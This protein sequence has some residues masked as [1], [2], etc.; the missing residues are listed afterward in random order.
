M[1][2]WPIVASMYSFAATP[3]TI[4]MYPKNVVIITLST[5]ISFSVDHGVAPMAFL[6]PNSRVRSFTVISIMFDTPTM[7]LSSVNSPIIH[8]AVWMMVMPVSICMLCVK[9]FHIHIAPSSSGAAWWLAFI[10]V[11]YLFSKASFASSVGSPWKE[12]TMKSALSPLLYMVRK[13]VNGVYML[14]FIPL[15]S[16]LYIPTTR[17]DM[18]STLTYSPMKSRRSPFHSSLASSSLMTTT[19]RRS[20]RSMSLMKRPQSMS[21]LFISTSLG[22]TPSIFVLT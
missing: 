21:F 17:N 20:R 1:V 8:S 9:R 10:L 15:L 6:I 18:F 7:P 12:N 16:A 5:I 4:P 19:F 11:L 22:Y 14:T 13:V 3:S 2:V